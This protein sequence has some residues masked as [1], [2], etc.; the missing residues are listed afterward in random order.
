MTAMLDV[1][2]FAANSYKELKMKM[3][4]WVR[5]NRPVKIVATNLVANGT[6]YNYC[7]VMFYE[8]RE[9]KLEK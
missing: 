9:L 6:E 7:Y 5:R 4:A 8:S 1:E 3:Q 2:V